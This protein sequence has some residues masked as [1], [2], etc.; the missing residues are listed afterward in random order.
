MRALRSP[1][2]RSPTWLGYRHPSS[3]CQ[4]KIGCVPS[5]EQSA[6]QSAEPHAEQS[7]EPTEGTIT[8]MLPA[9]VRQQ[10][11]V[12]QTRTLIRLIVN[13]KQHGVSSQGT[14][15]K[16]L[17]YTPQE[18]SRFMSGQEKGKA[19]LLSDL[20]RRRSSLLA[21]L[22]R[23]GFLTE[24]QSKEAPIEMPSAAPDA[25]TPTLSPREQSTCGGTAG[26][27][28]TCGGAAAGMATRGVGT[29]RETTAPQHRLPPPA[30]PVTALL[31]VQLSE[32]HGSHEGNLISPN[33]FPLAL[34]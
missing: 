10:Q 21:D 13:T 9:S 33:L 22:A 6:E 32:V 23:K 19:L 16:M 11:Q 20:V 30:A 28:P 27:G 31:T 12:T 34:W 1:S 7:A 29:P 24:A 17:G 14:L 5:S 8:A 15:A 26:A 18:L 3:L 4:T 2:Q 25:P